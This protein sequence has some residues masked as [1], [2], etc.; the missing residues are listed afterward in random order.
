MYR[1]LLF[2]NRFKTFFYFL[3]LEIL[4]VWLIV[5][6]NKYHNTAA[7]NTANYYVGNFLAFSDKLNNYFNLAVVNKALAEENALLKKKIEAN[8]FM[9]DSSLTS[10]TEPVVKNKFDFTVAKVVNLSTMRYNNYLTINKGT[11]DGVYPD[12]GVTGPSG[13]VG[14]VKSCSKNF[15]T[16]YSILHSGMYVSAKMQKNGASGTLRWEGTDFREASFLYVPRH[17]NVKLGDTIITS[18]FSAVYP[19][20]ILVGFVKK[21]DIKGDETFYRLQL[22]L[23]TDFSRLNYVYLVNNKLVAQQD[24]IEKVSTSD[25]DEKKQ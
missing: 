13:I 17:I 12:M 11:N 21:I 23:S 14:K 24:S 3:L 4:A 8:K 5:L 15:S 19:E 2:F 9:V 25:K 20:G 1:L 22:K 7:V 6:N 16:V 10:Q 18:G